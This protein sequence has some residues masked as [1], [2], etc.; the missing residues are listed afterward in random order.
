[1]S[2][3]SSLRTGLY[4]FGGL[5]LLGAIWVPQLLGLGLVIVIGLAIE[6]WRYKTPQRQPIDPRWQDTS[7]RFVDPETGAVTAV[8]FDP[9]SAERHYVVVERNERR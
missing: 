4:V 3:G 6:R 9:D 5:C 2:T 1:M 7:E 8:Y